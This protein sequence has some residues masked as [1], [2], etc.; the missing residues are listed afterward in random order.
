L[1]GKQNGN[2]LYVPVVSSAGKSLMPC[3]PA[4][5]N[6]LIRKGKALRRFRKGLFYIKLTEREDGDVQPIAC[7][8]DSGSKKE[9]FTVKS[10]AHT[11]LNLQASAV[12]W[13]KSAVETRRNMRKGRRQRKT[14][15]RKARWNRSSMKKEGRIP[16][17][18]KARWQL[19]LRI[20]SWLSKLFPIGHFV[21]ED[22]K[23]VTKKNARKWNRSFSPLEVGKKWFYE[24][25]EKLA[26]ITL[27]AG[28][29]TYNMR[30]NSGLKKLKNKLSDNFYAH[31]VDSWVLANDYVGGHITPDYTGVICLTPLRFS[32]RQLQVLQPAKGG[33]RKL[34]GSTRSLG[35]KRGSLVKHPKYGTCYVGGTSKNR[36]SL[37]SLETGERLTRNIKPSD[38]KL[39]TT[40]SWRVC[41]N[42]SQG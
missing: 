34:Y 12:V 32:R 40:L 17:S 14:P 5:A 36:I 41:S 2:I 29:D 9:S 26:P 24:Q 1:R 16:P 13:V 18:T 30:L 8:I 35:F 37:Y 39:L 20:A 11:Y 10:E 6:E 3:H 25:L 42:S 31:C 28:W 4:R 15:Y 21:I 33:Y 22:I 27:K 23:A 19:K 7:G 38:C